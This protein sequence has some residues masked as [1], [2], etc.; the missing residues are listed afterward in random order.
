MS[1]RRAL[2]V[3]HRRGAAL[4]AIRKSEAQ[5]KAIA[6]G[7]IQPG[8]FDESI[9]ALGREARKELLVLEEEFIKEVVGTIVFPA[10]VEFDTSGHFFAERSESR[11]KE[12][13]RA[14]ALDRMDRYASSH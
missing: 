5:D 7:S 2:E 9:A 13:I 3:A 14:K 1:A 4:A 10:Q 12:R 6:V 8:E 11:R